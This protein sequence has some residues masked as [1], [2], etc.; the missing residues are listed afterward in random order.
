MHLCIE[1]DGLVLIKVS[2]MSEGERSELFGRLKEDGASKKYKK[3]WG[4]GG[5]LESWREKGKRKGR[6]K[7]ES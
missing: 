3:R 5:K 1:T 6:K 2:R 7:Q 4:E